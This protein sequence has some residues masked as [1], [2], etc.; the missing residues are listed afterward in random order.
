MTV[1]IVSMDLRATYMASKIVRIVKIRILGIAC[2][3]GFRHVA[4]TEHIIGRTLHDVRH[5]QV[6]VQFSLGVE[7]IV[8]LTVP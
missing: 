5:A 3:L 1:G 7:R 4:F 6:F 8:L 2:S